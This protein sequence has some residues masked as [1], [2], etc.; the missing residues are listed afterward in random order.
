[1]VP[2]DTRLRRCRMP[3]L[4]LTYP[5]G[6]RRMN[7]CRWPSRWRSCRLGRRRTRRRMGR[8]GRC[9]CRMGR[10]RRGIRIAR[11]S[12][13]CAAAF[14]RRLCR[15][16]LGICRGLGN[17]VASLQRFLVRR[18]RRRGGLVRG[19]CRSCR[20]AAMPHPI[21]RS[22]AQPAQ[23]KQAEDDPQLRGSAE[24]YLFIVAALLVFFR[25]LL[26]VLG[27]RFVIVKNSAHIPAST[28]FDRKNASSSRLSASRQA[29]SRACLRRN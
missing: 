22:E 16:R 14:V 2:A 24:R 18:G 9:R 12:R 27:F 23:Q 8:C 3:L 15:W 17:R 11:W 25:E 19:G 5:F 1:M 29:H 21:S 7:R 26:S 6:R 4:R 20:R 28:A 10:R 13:R